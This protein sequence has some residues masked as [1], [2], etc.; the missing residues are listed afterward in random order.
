MAEVQGARVR[1]RVTRWETRRRINRPTA[2]AKTHRRLAGGSRMSQSKSKS[3]SNVHGLQVPPFPEDDKDQSAIEAE[4]KKDAVG[5]EEE[6]EA[7]KWAGDVRYL[8]AR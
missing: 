6:A 4:K 7:R 8:K 5:R 3:R 1:F 2:R